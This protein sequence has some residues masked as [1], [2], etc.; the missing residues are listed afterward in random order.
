MTEIK[1]KIANKLIIPDA[2]PEKPGAALRVGRIE[3]KR[4]RR[5]SV[6]ALWKQ[7]LVSGAINSIGL[8]AEKARK[9]SEKKNEPGE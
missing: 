9:M 1:S 8:R 3:S 7:G 6:F 5:Y 2:N 4:E